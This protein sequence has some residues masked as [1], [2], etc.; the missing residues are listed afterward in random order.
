MQPRIYP[1]TESAISS[2]ALTESSC[3]KRQL[4]H[5][6]RQPSPPLRLEDV[7]VTGPELPRDQEAG[8]S[9][10]K[11]SD[12]RVLI[13]SSKARV[14]WSSQGPPFW[15]TLPPGLGYGEAVGNALSS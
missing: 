4:L 6:A 14:G 3:H 1:R 5:R 15:L 12:L 13:E 10:A 11:L 7:L 8:L 9:P 2:W